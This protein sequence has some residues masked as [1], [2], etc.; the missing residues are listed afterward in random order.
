M[1]PFPCTSWKMFTSSSFTI[2][3]AIKNWEPSKFLRFR[4]TRFSVLGNRGVWDKR[5][6]NEGN[7]RTEETEPKKKFPRI[8]FSNYVCIVWV[9]NNK[10]RYQCSMFNA[11]YSEMQSVERLHLFFFFTIYFIYFYHS[12]TRSMF[13]FHVPIHAIASKT[14]VLLVSSQKFRLNLL[15]RRFMFILNED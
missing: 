13:G 7:K 12:S 3:F 8:K 14:Y 10:L 4:S 9:N 6:A 1:L 2:N 15:V 5:K 11:S